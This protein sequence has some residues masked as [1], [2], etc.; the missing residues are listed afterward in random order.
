MKRM[1]KRNKAFT[2]IE[3][4][5]VIAIIAI[6]ML[7][8]T[9]AYAGIRER[10]QVRADKSTAGQIGKSLVVREIDV[11]K[12][13]GVPLYPEIT[14]YDELDKVENYVARDIK[15]QSMKDGNFYVTAFQT[16]NGK[17]I[18]VGIGREGD[19]FLDKQL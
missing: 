11:R 19:E 10:M 18:V 4:I 14:R 9:V 13:D 2:L 15:P 7:I 16:Q 5:V 17:K 8:G 6:I 1:K 3:L 12:E